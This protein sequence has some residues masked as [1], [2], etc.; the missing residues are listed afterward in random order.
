MCP[1]ILNH[2]IHMLLQYLYNLEVYGHRHFA[3]RDP[4]ALA[5]AQ[6]AVTSRVA[7]GELGPL[8]PLD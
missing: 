5:K 1:A 4:A 2:F 3:R 8:S 6:Q 7:T